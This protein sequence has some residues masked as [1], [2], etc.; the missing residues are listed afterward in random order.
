M[1]FASFIKL[2]NYYHNLSLKHFKHQ[3]EAPYLLGIPVYPPLQ[4]Q[5]ITFCFNEF[6]YSGYFM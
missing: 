1:I 4:P 5:E 2:C 6:A 3:K